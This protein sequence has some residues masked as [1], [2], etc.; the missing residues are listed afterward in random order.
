MWGDVA[1]LRLY[2][3]MFDQAEIRVVKDSLVLIADC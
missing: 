1:V 3:V 2:V